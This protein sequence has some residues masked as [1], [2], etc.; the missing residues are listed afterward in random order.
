[1]EFGY[2]TVTVDVN[3][4]DHHLAITFNDRSNTRVHDTTHLNLRTG[5]ILAR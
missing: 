5:K 1:V 2:L 4:R 3:G